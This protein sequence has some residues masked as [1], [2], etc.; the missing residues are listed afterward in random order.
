MRLAVEESA[1]A[2]SGTARLWRGVALVAALLLLNLM[3]TFHNVWPT[4]FVRPSG[5]LSIELAGTLLL[6]AAWRGLRGAPPRGL[7]VVLAIAFLLGTLGRYAEVTAPA[8][9]GREVNLYWDLPHVTSLT[10]MVTRVASAW[11]ILALIVGI[12]AGLASLYFVALWSLRRVAGA[13]ESPHMRVALSIAASAVI[14]GF[15]LENLREQRP[16]IPRFA[17]P[18]SQT[19][20][21]QF[22]KVGRAI[23]EHG[24]LRELP[25][26]PALS[27]TLSVIG[28]SDVIVVFVESYGRVAYDRHDFFDALAPARAALADAARDTGRSIASGYVLSP[29]FGGGSWLA[30][31]NFLSGVEVRDTGRAQLLMTQTRRT[32]GNALAEHGYRRVGLMPGLKWNWPEGVFYG[33]D[34]IYDDASLDYRG[35]SFGWWRIPDQF[36][37]AK[38]DELELAPRAAGASAR[39]PV[40]T[41]FPTINT[42]TPFRPTPPYQADWSRMLSANPFDEAALRQSLQQQPGWN[43]M[44]E[45]YQGSVAYSLQTL[46]GYLRK[47]PRDDLIIIVVG[48]HQ[49]PAM[50]SGLNAPWD[51][52]VHIITSNASVLAT[53]QGCGFVPGVVPAPEAL[54]GMYQLAPT[55]LYAFGTAA[56]QAGAMGSSGKCPLGHPTDANGQHAGAS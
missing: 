39:E 31:L 14:V 40:F 56:P 13:L 6:L 42:H 27:S 8:L 55:L 43:D 26:S 4:I 32:F 19:Y 53:L 38:L 41:F 12:V 3:L 20:A 47:Q 35:P 28:R 52:P 50:V 51:V 16:V 45:S 24:A 48:D 33:F 44:A 17:R 46:A 29:T 18:I 37:L 2:A 5:E 15:T 9:Y 25:P 30:H 49:P 21:E 22:A 34:Q 1:G 54:G 23:T 36:S 11:M 7:L 10:G